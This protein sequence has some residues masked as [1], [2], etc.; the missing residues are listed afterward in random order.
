MENVTFAQPPA[1]DELPEVYNSTPGDDARL[2]VRFYRDPVHDRDRCEIMP[3]GDIRLVVDQ[4]VTEEHR[5]RFAQLWQAY[6][7]GRDAAHDGTPIGEVTWLD[8]AS[9]AMLNARRVYTVEQLAGL[10]ESAIEAGDIMGL[11]VFRD[12]AR[13]HLQ[14]TARAMGVNQLVDENAELRARI[15]A[16]EA[17]RA[18]ASQPPPGTRPPRGGPRKK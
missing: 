18:N 4:V 2:S 8:A 5:I 7:E 10:N 1:G 14:R 13:T 17:D 15:E 16:L 9:I 12:R 6:S 3:R 11:G